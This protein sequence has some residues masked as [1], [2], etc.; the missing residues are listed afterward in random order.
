MGLTDPLHLAYGR[1]QEERLTRLFTTAEGVLIAVFTPV[2]GLLIDLYG[3][4]DRVLV[5]IGLCFLL[6]LTLSALTS[7]VRS[8]KHPQRSKLP[9]S[10][11]R[12]RPTR[13]FRPGYSLV[14][15]GLAW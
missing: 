7:V 3:S 1:T 12:E 4:V 2:V 6:V 14:R 9:R 8:L 5:I 15:S 11:L 13:A 10:A